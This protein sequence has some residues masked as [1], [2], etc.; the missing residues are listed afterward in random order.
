VRLAD[1]ILANV[2]PILVEW[3]SFARS[4]WPSGATADP[5]EVRDEAEDI[6]YATAAD[7]QSDQTSAQQAEKSK[8]A[9]RAWNEGAALTRASATHGSGRVASGFEL[10]AVVAEYRALRASVLHLWRESGPT[11]DLRDVDDVTR[12]NESIDQSLTQAV[13]SYVDQ[14]ER[15]RA[16]LLANAH[17]S[18]REAEAANRAKDMFLATLSHEMRTPLNAIVG[19]LSILRHE[20][21]DPRHVQEGLKVIERNTATQLQLIDDVLDVSRIVSG[22]LRVD[23]HPCDLTDVIN[24]GVNIMRPAAEA[25]SITLNVQLDPSASGAWCDSVRIQQVVWNL[26]SNAVKFTPKGG[27]VDVTLSRERSSFQIQVMDNGQGISSELLPYVFD[28]FRQGD[29]STRRRFAGLGLGLSIVK[30]IVEAH[31]GTVEANSPGEGKGSTFTVRLPIRAVGIGEA[32]EE[33]KVASTTGGE[34]EPEDVAPVIA[35]RPLV[36]LDGLRVL[37]VDDEADARRVLALVLE[38][39]GAIVTATGSVRE[40]IE[41]LPKARPDVLVSDLGMPDQDG[42]DLIRQ[43]RDEGYDASDLPAVALTAFVQKDD[44]RLA[45]LAG[46]QVHVP[47]P[48]DPHDLTSVIAR[49]AG[50]RRL[51]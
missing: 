9:S 40:A 17:A 27:R 26:V 33:G 30:Y 43:V 48:I 38:Q 16:A 34:G 46:F 20:Q 36:R 15:D 21:A 11:P 29:S 13:R 45:L 14:V 7:M 5:A 51:A 44:A 41:A 47:K 4:I 6:L 24:S 10:W 50:R 39:V 18:R 32:G 22:K 31:G 19:W 8:G 49:L 1:F 23:I 25:R 42:F 35:S 2:E 12:F 3:E 37:V 28:R